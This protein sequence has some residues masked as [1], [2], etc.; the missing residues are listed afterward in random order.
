MARTTGSG[1]LRR[2]DRRRRKR[3]D[4][5]AGVALIER[6]QSRTLLSGTGLAV[7]ITDGTLFVRDESAGDDN[8]ITI[9]VLEDRVQI[10]DSVAEATVA[11]GTQI[12]AHT[13]EVPLDQITTRRVAT[14][15]NAGDDT[16]TVETR[17]GI[18]LAFSFAGGD[19]DDSWNVAGTA[20][21]DQI[22][23]ALEPIPGAAISVTEQAWIDT[24][25]AGFENELLVDDDHRL[26]FVSG[27]TNDSRIAVFDFDGNRVGTIDDVPGA[28]G[29][30]LR[31][32]ELFVAVRNEG[33]VDVIHIPTLTKTRRYSLGEGVLPT[34]LAF[35]GGDLF[36]AQ[37][38]D[39][40][41]NFDVGRLNLETGDYS[42]AFGQREFTNAKLY[43]DPGD[44]AI[45]FIAETG[46]SP[47]WADRFRVEGDLITELDGIGAGSNLRDLAASPDSDH[48]WTAAGSPYEIRESLP[49]SIVTTYATGAYPRSVSYSPADGG[50]IVAASTV[51]GG[52]VHVFQRGNSDA[53]FTSRIGSMSS[54]RVDALATRIFGLLE[55]QQLVVTK[56]S[57]RAASVDGT[58]SL[59]IGPGIEL[60]SIDS[61]DDD[62]RIMA[63]GIPAGVTQ[64]VVN[65]GSGD[66]LVLGSGGNDQ[67]S[68]GAGSDTLIGGAGND[69]LS[70]GD[71]NDTLRGSAGRDHLDGGTG[72]DR[73]YGQSGADVLIQSV[74]DNHLDWMDGG[75]TSQDT[76]R[77]I[78]DGASLDLDSMQ[79]RRITSVEVID[80]RASGRQTLS[81]SPASLTA[82]GIDAARLTVNRSSADVVERGDGWASQPDLRLSP[83][84]AFQ[85]FTAGGRELRIERA[86]LADVH[87]D[88][89]DAPISYDSAADG[90]AAHRVVAG[91]PR[92]GRLYDY[93]TAPHTSDDASGDGIEED[94]VRFSPELYTVSGESTRGTAIV[95]VSINTQLDAWIDFNA[96]GDFSDPGEQIASSLALS[97]GDNLVDFTVPGDAVVGPTFARFRVST[98]G[99]LTPS[100]IAPDGEVE[101]YAVSIRAGTEPARQTLLLP[102]G[103][104]EFRVSTIDDFIE[105]SRGADLI[106]RL[107]VGMVSELIILGSS[108]S[109]DL[110][111]NSLPDSLDGLVT[112]RG[113]MGNDQIR[114]DGLTIS[115]RIDGDNGWD[116][117]SGGAG[118][119]TIDGGTGNDL[120]IGGDGNDRIEGGRGQDTLSGG[121]GNDV[122]LG[123]S[124]RDTL[125]GGG[126]IDQLNGGGSADTVV[127]TGDNDFVLT[128]GMLSGVEI[129]QLTSIELARLTGGDGHNRIDASAFPGSVTLSGGMGNDT[130]IGGSGDDVI[131]G[132]GGRDWVEGGAGND[133]VFG[134]GGSG[135]TIRGGTGQDTLSGGTGRDTLSEIDVVRISVWEFVSYRVV[136]ATQDV[137]QIPN[138]DIE[139]A[140]LVGTSGDDILDALQ[141][142]G[143]VTLLGGDGDDQLS[144]SDTAADVLRG[145]AGN[146]QLAGF[147]GDDLLFGD[148]G[149]DLLNGGAGHDTLRG[150]DGLDTVTDDFSGVYEINAN[151]FKPYGDGDGPT[152]SMPDADFEQAE[153]Y[154]WDG[155][156]VN[157]IDA[158]EFPGPVT[159]AGA[160]GTDI[161]IGT[162]YDDL[163][164][165]FGGNDGLDG[166]AGNDSLVGGDGNDTIFGDIGDDTIS[167]GDGDDLLDGDDFENLTLTDD[168]N[169]DSIDGGDGRDTLWGGPGNDILNGGAQD[170]VL[171][172]RSGDD[173]LNGGTGVDTLA[174]GSGSGPDAG[175]LFD[176]ADEIDEAFTIDWYSL[177]PTI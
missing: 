140:V 46:G 13:V 5:R 3:R 164:I 61:D 152:S 122:L 33:A 27:G 23:L 166:L 63:N 120:L 2:S 52:T 95:A 107:P 9:R 111:I 74:G 134:Q 17:D 103:G 40:Y 72:D 132:G 36:V 20:A 83:E 158:S 126:G 157:A 59:G 100:G 77:L 56:L 44:A 73:L 169:A 144:G 150:G 8:Q 22:D 163:L 167:G 26:V 174:G 78:G 114:A 110:T 67:L 116:T 145:G 70:G 123:Q 96:D 112:V 54:V 10:V 45:L 115:I 142:P 41:K 87:F 98:D 160:G 94:G 136:G 7:E 121:A 64:L 18:S 137:S 155:S 135:D 88:F 1:W 162:V 53:L 12:D 149:D 171:M 92:L 156:R 71:G 129:D 117:I 21:A 50:I 66:D 79:S 104:G 93:E 84:I 90:P 86:A 81:F 143:S 141:F 118:S 6:L 151:D 29:I 89:G 105:L 133:R 11:T 47:S 97:A 57:N 42:L 55:N 19:G 43:S 161:L 119:D 125:F 30:T 102:S 177:L 76:L 146:D 25:L 159:L 32:D 170:D 62:D 113:G 28:R 172:G 58:T 69:S 130:L 128:A 153:L 91:G 65:G 154:A 37:H 80:L 16:L 60:L 176:A 147:G 124:A 24:G 106:N 127:D 109:D 48:V 68:G 82:G 175:D 51:S 15:G 75:G 39:Y 139:M 35:A 173:Q 14:Y 49:D 148:E 108:D 31:G 101:D 85:Q 38:T 34:S 165:G 4:H 99:G 138:G 131:L 168:G